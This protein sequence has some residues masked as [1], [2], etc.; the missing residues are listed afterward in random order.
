MIT[1][2]LALVLQLY[3]TRSLPIISPIGKAVVARETTIVSREFSMLNRYD[4]EFVN[5]VFRKNILLT[6]AYMRKI[7]P[8]TGKI[9]WETVNKP[10]TWS[11]TLTPGETISFQSFLLPKYKNAIPLTSLTFSSDEGFLSD[12]WLVGDGVCHLASLIYW[13]AKDAGLDVLA[14]TNHDFAKINDVPKE[15][16]VAIYTAPSAPEASAIQ[17][18]YIGNNRDQIVKLVFTYADDTLKVSVVEAKSGLAMTN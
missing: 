12:G 10:F 7:V 6:L 5:D 9:D 17:N 8:E 13:A 18:L 15:Y 4:N 1:L 16:G 3:V 2:L 11:V 14:P